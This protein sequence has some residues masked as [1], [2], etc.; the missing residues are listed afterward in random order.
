MLI[1]ALIQEFPGS[2]R[3]EKMERS[4][5]IVSTN[6]E[7]SKAI[8]GEVRKEMDHV[9]NHSPRMTSCQIYIDEP[10][11]HQREVPIRLKFGLRE[12]SLL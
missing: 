6:V 8:E 1:R 9:T 12:L 2:Q 10:H 5:E 4:L 11:R 3:H 7:P